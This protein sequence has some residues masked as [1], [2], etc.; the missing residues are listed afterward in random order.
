MEQKADNKK[1]IV[2]I[3]IWV[4]VILAIMASL[5]IAVNNLDALE[6]IRQLHGG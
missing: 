3:V 4:V 6:V 1:K 2:K 5:H